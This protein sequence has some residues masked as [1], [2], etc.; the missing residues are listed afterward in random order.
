MRDV[1]IVH[2]GEFELTGVDLL[3]KGH[4]LPVV[5]HGDVLPQKQDQH[6]GRRDRKGARSDH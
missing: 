2:I 4:E 6:Q 5:Y 1:L 3:E